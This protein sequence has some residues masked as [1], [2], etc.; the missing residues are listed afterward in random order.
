MEIWILTSS[1]YFSTL[2]NLLRAYEHLMIK[3][4]ST[5]TKTKTN[6]IGKDCYLKEYH[7]RHQLWAKPHIGI[8]SV[9]I[10][11]THTKTIQL[12]II[13][14]KKMPLIYR[15]YY[16]PVLYVAKSALCSWY[17]VTSMQFFLIFFSNFGVNTSM[18]TYY[19]DFCKKNLK[20][21]LLLKQYLS[22]INT[23]F[24]IFFRQLLQYGKP[25]IIKSHISQQLTTIMTANN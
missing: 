13:I 9:E 16:Y 19:V 4:S 14:I 22:T 17:G 1:W 23:E 12:W 5:K 2:T 18:Q 6:E 8:G 3:K 20:L 10:S 11:H 24:H 25:K 15:H 21:R 7:G